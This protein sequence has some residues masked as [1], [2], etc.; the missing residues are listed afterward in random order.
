MFSK[1]IDKKLMLYVCNVKIVVSIFH[2]CIHFLGPYIEEALNFL[3]L[4]LCVGKPDMPDLSVLEGKAEKN[5]YS[6]PVKQGSDGGSPVTYYV[7][8]WRMV[9]MNLN[10]ANLKA[11]T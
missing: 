2:K 7:V 3:L 9:S 11:V 4:F 6:I 8:R 1:S 10:Y 5:S